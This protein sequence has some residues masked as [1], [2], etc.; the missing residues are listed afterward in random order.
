MSGTTAEC[1]QRKPQEPATSSILSVDPIAIA[2][3]LRN[4][5]RRS[6]RHDVFLPFFTTK[7]KG[8]GV[9]LSLAR[10][11]VLAHQGSITLLEGQAGGALF[12]IVI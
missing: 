5:S 8:T 11:V 2:S 10:Q 4:R 12:R 6:L 7:A 9:G 3:S 1:A